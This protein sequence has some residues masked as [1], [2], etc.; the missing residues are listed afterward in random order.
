MLFVVVEGMRLGIL[1]NVDWV[2]GSVKFLIGLI[3]W[4]C[5]YNLDCLIMVFM[6]V[7]CVVIMGLRLFVF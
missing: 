5:I 2:R 7:V 6:F 4:G 1:F 3:L